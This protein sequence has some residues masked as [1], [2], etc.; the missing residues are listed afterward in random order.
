SASVESLLGVINDI[1]DFSKIEAGKLELE[2]R[3]FDLEKA[4]NRLMG[5]F[6]AEADEK[7]LELIL[8]Y[9]SDA[10]RVVIGDSIRIRQVLFNLVGNAVKFTENGHVWVNVD[11]SW[12]RENEALFVIKVEDTGIGVPGSKLDHIFDHYAQADASTTRNFGGTGLG[13]AI[14][15]QLVALMGGRIEVISAP[16]RGST[17]TFELK[18]ALDREAPGEAPEMSELEE[19]RVLV[20]DDNRINRRIFSE[21]LNSRN[22]RHDVA[23]DARAA[24][25]TLRQARWSRDPHCLLVTDLIMP[26]MDGEAL[27]RAVKSDND[28]KDTVVVLVSSAGGAGDSDHLRQAGFSGF[29]NKPVGMNDF[30]KLLAAAMERSNGPM[31]TLHDFEPPLEYESSRLPGTAD[32]RVL[33]VEDNRINQQ[34]AAAI[35]G[36]IGFRNIEIARN[37][38]IACEMVQKSRYDLLL[39]DIQMPV[40]DGYKATRVIRELEGGFTRI[41]IIAM[42]ANAI[43]GDKEKCLAAGMDDYISKPVRKQGLLKVLSRWMDQG[44]ARPREQQEKKSRNEVEA[45]A[46]E[47]NAVVSSVFNYEDAVGRYDGDAELLRG[48]IESFLDDTPRL[49]EEIEAEATSGN[50]DRAGGKSHALKGGA[51]YIG[52]ERLRDV[53]FELEKAGR[54]GDESAA[55]TLLSGLKAEFEVFKKEIESYDWRGGARGDENLR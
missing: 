33:L 46:G 28:L 5:I 50:P 22:V 19:G 3:A 2:A 8:R 34:A 52:A 1:L 20:V 43:E 35:L 6:A 9:D 51:S 55:S 14:C 4:V 44:A 37:G 16:D 54:S 39:M 41:P 30:L 53:A 25:S 7:E 17:F 24:L 26:D 32:T 11:C 36:K 42:T 18:L 40:M 15:K 47:E 45:P 38:R 48:I 23:P 13:L 31:V 49:I 10:P 12:A 21:Y 27:C 29:L